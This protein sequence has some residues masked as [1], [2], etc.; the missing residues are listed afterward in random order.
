MITR[1][2]FFSI[3]S[4]IFSKHPL[5][6]VSCGYI[7]VLLEWVALLEVFFFFFAF[8]YIRKFWTHLWN[9][10]TKYLIIKLLTQGGLSIYI[11]RQ[12][13]DCETM[14][15]RGCGTDIDCRFNL[16]NIKVFLNFIKFPMYLLYVF[17]LAWE[18]AVGSCLSAGCHDS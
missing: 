6:L 13:G 2:L 14:D 9:Y 11:V 3:C 5:I 15:C 12:G 4:L 8:W 7:K 10:K 17:F 18:R 1:S 16:N